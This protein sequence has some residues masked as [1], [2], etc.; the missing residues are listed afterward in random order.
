M[1]STIVRIHDVPMGC[2]DPRDDKV[3]ET[4]LNANADVIVSRDHDDR[5]LELRSG[6]SVER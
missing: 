4:A 6:S 2:R 1:S 3:I 5:P